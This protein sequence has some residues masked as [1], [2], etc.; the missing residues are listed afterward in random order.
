VAELTLER[1]NTQAADA[2]SHFTLDDLPHQ[3]FAGLFTVVG[4]S[5]TLAQ[6]SPAVVGTVCA[7]PPPPLFA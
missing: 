7:K 4:A 5:L 3:P 6:V 1:L 2:Y